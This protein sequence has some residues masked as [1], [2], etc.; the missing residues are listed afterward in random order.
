VGH[1]R[2]DEYS[3]DAESIFAIHITKQAAV[4]VDFTP[5]GLEEDA[6]ARERPQQRRR[7]VEAGFASL[8]GVHAEDAYPVFCAIEGNVE[9]VA[10]DDVNDGCPLHGI[11]VSAEHLWEFV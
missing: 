2:C 10:I 11:R 3:I 5:V 7:L 8:G 1:S 4:T 9:R 6:V